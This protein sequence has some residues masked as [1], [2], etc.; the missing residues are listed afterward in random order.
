[1]STDRVQKVKRE[2][3]YVFFK[4]FLKLLAITKLV[5]STNIVFYFC[6]TTFFALYHIFVYNKLKTQPYSNQMYRTSLFHQF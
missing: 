2:P 5:V 1:M 3:A 6:S 4:L